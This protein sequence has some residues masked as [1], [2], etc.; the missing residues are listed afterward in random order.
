MKKEAEPPEIR[1]EYDFSQ[2]VRGRYADRFQGN[3]RSELL[4]SAA[5]LDSQAWLAHSLLSFQTLESYLVAYGAMVLHY[6]PEAAGKAV[7]SLMGQ[8]HRLS[9]SAAV[10]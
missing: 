6:E 1:P 9:T 3:T 7:T 4:R 2:G 8:V 10:S 5:V